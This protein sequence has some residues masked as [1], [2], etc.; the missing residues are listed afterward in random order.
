MNTK[1][2]DKIQDALNEKAWYK[3]LPLVDK[4][5]VLEDITVS[6]VDQEEVLRKLYRACYVGYLEILG[7]GTDKSEEDTINTM[8]LALESYR[9]M[10]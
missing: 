9:S 3:E 6:I 7:N 1:I 8:Q 4:I 2:I 5:D 10:R